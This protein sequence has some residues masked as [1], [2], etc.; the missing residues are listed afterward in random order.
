L[1]WLI[2]VAATAGGGWLADRA[3][4]PSSYLFVALLV[5]L[6]FALLA[7]GRFEQ[8]ETGFRVGQV[9]TG[10][11]IG[12]FLE[13]STLTGLG[14]QWIAVLLVSAATLALTVAAGIVLARATGI[15]RPTA[16]LGMVAGGAS[17][18]V[19]MADDLGGDDRLVAF[20]QYARVLVISLLTPLLVPIAFPAAHVGATA[21]N[22][23]LL[24]GLDGWALTIGAS[25]VGG[26]VATRLRIPAPLVLGPLLVA[27]ALSLGGAIDGVDV[28]PLLREV[29]F[30]LIGLYIGLGFDRNALRRIARLL[31]PVAV[32]IAGLLV[33]SFGLA[34]V[35]TAAVDVTL[36]DAYL[37]TTPGGLYAVLPIAYGS[38]ADA[39]FVLAVQGLRLF[40]MI[41]AAPL[42]VRWV[43]RAPAPAS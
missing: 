32:A 11:A 15:D 14:S 4:V 21:G 36:L 24:G 33:V 37:A 41:L 5:G 39:T 42:V 34:V 12:T 17:G 25:L 2:A 7:P 9:I 38:G 27:A 18:I 30:A 23:P 20:M 22:G 3:G 19:A 31:V 13:S 29:G 26:L 43:V 6:A 40:A 8:P 10:V 1:N 35:L 28:P 16:A